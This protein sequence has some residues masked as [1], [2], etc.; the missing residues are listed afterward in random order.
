MGNFAT[1][2]TT[3]PK[4]RIQNVHASHFASTSTPL[5]LPTTVRIIVRFLFAYAFFTQQLNWLLFKPSSKKAEGYFFLKNLYLLRSSIFFF[6][7]IN[8]FPLYAFVS[9]KRQ[10]LM[11]QFRLSFFISSPAQIGKFGQ[12]SLTKT[13]SVSRLARHSP[14]NFWSLLPDFLRFRRVSWL[15]MA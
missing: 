2:L 8:F 10:M 13:F 1:W 6:F 7:I 5:H 3:K 15:I 9:D 14:L 4:G 12:S 11:Q